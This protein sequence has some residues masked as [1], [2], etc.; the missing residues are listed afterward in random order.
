METII[1]TGASGDIGSA[2]ALQLA[3]RG[4]NLALI[5]HTNVEA[6]SKTAEEVSAL[7]SYCRTYAGNLGS[8]AF[9]R[10][11]F[12]QIGDEFH[13]IDGLVHVAGHSVTGLLSDLTIE[14]WNNLVSANLTSAI[15]CIKHVTP[16]MLARKNGRILLI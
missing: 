2:V 11:V 8:E 7:G 4:V 16:A 12:E 6:L 3:K 13:R 5:G 14:E 15:L 1:V 10:E 9:V